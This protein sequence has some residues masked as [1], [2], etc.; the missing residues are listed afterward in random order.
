MA[1]EYAEIYV[2]CALTTVPD[3]LRRTLKKDI[4]HIVNAVESVREQDGLAVYA[5][6][7]I[8]HTAPFDDLGD[9]HRGRETPIQPDRKSGADYSPE[10]IWETD[11]R[12]VLVEADG[13]IVHG[14][15][16]GSSGV[17]MEL[18]MASCRGIPILYVH[19][20]TATVSRMVRGMAG[21]VSIRQFMVAEDTGSREHLEQIVRDWLT[22]NRQLIERGPS[23]R[24]AQG[25]LVTPIHQ[26]L[27]EA[28]AG[29]PNED[30]RRRR[31]A[32]ALFSRAEVDL[33][34]AEPM[35]LAYL[36]YA[37]LLMLLR[38]LE[39]D[40]GTMGPTKFD[41]GEREWLHRAAEEYGWGDEFTEAVA[42]RA[43]R[44]LASEQRIARSSSGRHNL[45]SVPGWA[46]F[47]DDWISGRLA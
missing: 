42:S 10:E 28:W 47:A 22:E 18:H 46:N 45:R 15:G 9:E 11:T 16:G 13:V 4:A 27:I 25:R 38:A 29:L 35:R 33:L 32:L 5:Y 12:K 6:D 8:S 20:E 44:Y 40:R 23:S 36:P 17:G 24:A 19:H 3:P 2:A 26:L 41:A 30:E 14:F 43:R 31:A 1:I 21:N 39:V 7:P 34:L 37:R